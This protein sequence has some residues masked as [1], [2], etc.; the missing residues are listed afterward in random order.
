MG[1]FEKFKE[2][3]KMAL[4][5]VLSVLKQPRYALMAVAMAVI[6]AL[7]VYIMINWS[8]Y[9]S[10]L[11]SRLPFVDKIAVFGLMARQMFADFFT[12]TNGLMLL[13][14]SILQGMSIAT[15]IYVM[16]RNKQFETRAV[17]GSSFAAIATALGLGCVPCGTSIIMPIVTLLFSSSAYMAASIASGVILVLAFIATCYSL[18]TLGNTA[19]TYKTLHEQK[20]INKKGKD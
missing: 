19:Y 6:F 13:I 20:I 4:Q 16:R 7:L 8:V 11:F 9:G 15:T 1:K 17:G 14:V 10:L 3:L 2:K 5:G 18:Y 12:T